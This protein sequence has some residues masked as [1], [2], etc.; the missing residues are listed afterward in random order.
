[1]PFISYWVSTIAEVGVFYPKTSLIKH[2]EISC[3]SPCDIIQGGSEAQSLSGTRVGDI[4]EKS[5]SEKL[6]SFTPLE[7]YGSSKGETV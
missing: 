7:R 2:S 1:M 6:H 5:A 3:L 4:T